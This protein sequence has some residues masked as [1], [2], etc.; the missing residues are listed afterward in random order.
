[1]PTYDPRP[2]FVP[3]PCY[4]DVKAALAWLQE[5]FGF[6]VHMIIADADDNIVHSEMSYAGGVVMI[7]TEWTEDHKSPANVDSKNTQSIH[8]QV[9]EDI[10]AHCERA[11]KAG[12]KIV[13][14]PETQ[15]YGD[16]T[17]RCKDLEG[18]VWT[19]GQTVQ[20]MS[21]EDW[22]KAIPGIKTR[23]TL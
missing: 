5:A 17:Y 9:T 20:R 14:E 6:D 8:V 13:A 10:S 23:T 18:H 1:M 4:R 2:T 15:F 3:C 12:A 19:F 11:R 7:G 16:R 22:D 21:S